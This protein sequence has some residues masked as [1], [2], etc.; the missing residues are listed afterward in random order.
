MILNML[1]LRQYTKLFNSVKIAGN[2]YYDHV[3]L[4]F[5]K[6]T[7]SFY[8]DSTSVRV[9]LLVEGDK[10]VDYLYV[11]GL[12]FFFL[13]NSYDKL[14]IRKGKFYSDKKDRFSLP[15]IDEDLAFSVQEDYTGEIR[16]LHFSRSFIEDLDICREFLE[17][18]S[19]FPAVFFEKRDI[20]ALSQSKC[21]QAPSGF[22]ED[23]SFA[24]PTPVIR[25]LLSLNIQE[26]DDIEFRLKESA[27]GGQIIEFNYRDLLYKF[28]SSSDVELPVD[29]HSEEFTSSFD[30]KEYFIIET[31]DLVEALRILSSFAKIDI[32][33]CEVLFE[34]ETSIKMKMFNESEIEYNIDIES[35]SDYEFFKD[36]SFWI[37]LHG[38]SSAVSSMAKK[39]IEN[40]QIHYSDKEPAI[41]LLDASRTQEIFIVQTLIEKPRA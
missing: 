35:Y 26:D 34:S 21:I 31:S 38:L 24:V 23:T 19:N 28:A 3:F 12:K 22:V 27:N 40:I 7:M 13:V 25:A 16:Q 20:V 9:D 5:R 33:H 15:V 2:A 6:N 10:D 1:N 18:S 39:R 4:D 8:T 36:K 30:H 14:E 29:P 32:G 17:K 11:D 41:K 37:S